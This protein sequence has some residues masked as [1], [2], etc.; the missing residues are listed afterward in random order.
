MGRWDICGYGKVREIGELGIFAYSG[1]GIHRGMLEIGICDVFIG[2]YVSISDGRVGV[3]MVGNSIMEIG[4]KPGSMV[5][6]A[7]SI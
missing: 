6:V 1:D 4:G 5:I 2:S 3:D 7:V